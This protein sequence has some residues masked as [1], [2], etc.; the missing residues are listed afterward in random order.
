MKPCKKKEPKLSD[1]GMQEWLL[2]T[3]TEISSS[4]EMALVLVTE[5]ANR[6]YKA[7]DITLTLTSFELADDLNLSY[8][9]ARSI[10]SDLRKEGKI[11]SIGNN[12]KY[13]I[14]VVKDK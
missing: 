5:A 2:S 6:A 8:S 9:H 14:P 11:T 4:K 3:H 12:P 10:L 1:R 13:W 7:K